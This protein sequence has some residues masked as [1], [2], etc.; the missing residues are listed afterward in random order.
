[1]RARV[2]AERLLARDE[3][4]LDVIAAGVG[5]GDEL[6]GAAVEQQRRAGLLSDLGVGA[7][8]VPG[9]LAKVVNS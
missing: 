2:G 6:V 4:G 7:G 9:G 3:V 1:M 5:R 8:S